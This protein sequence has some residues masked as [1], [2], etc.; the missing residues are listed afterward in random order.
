MREEIKRWGEERAQT[1]EVHTVSQ[2]GDADLA[3]V[4]CGCHSNVEGTLRNVISSIGHSNAQ[5]T[6]R[7]EGEELHGDSCNNRHVHCCGTENR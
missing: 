2:A 4:H 7:Q 3:E 1:G 5:G 6:L